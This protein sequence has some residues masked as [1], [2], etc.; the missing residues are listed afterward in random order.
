[1]KKIILIFLIVFGLFAV[2]VTQASAG[3]NLVWSG[4]DSGSIPTIE[5]S[6]TPQAAQDLYYYLPSPYDCF[7]DD[8]PTAS[9][10]NNCYGFLLSWSVG[11]GGGFAEKWVCTAG[12]WRETC[13]PRNYPCMGCS[14]KSGSWDVICDNTTTIPQATTTTSTPPTLINLSSFTAT[15]KFS[16]VIIQWSTGSEIDNAGFYIYRAT[17]EN[18]EYEKIN[19]VL[20]TAEGSATNG[21]SY[22]FTDTDVQNRRTYYYKLEDIDL[23]GKSTMHGP[24]SATPRLIYG[25]KK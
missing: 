9:F 4:D 7:I 25:M 2:N 18:G 22:T 11:L 6:R 1:M 8:L 21:A 12:N 16:K 3:C 19:N 15:P 23:N 14:G 5:T 17:A 10:G 13:H 24:V 20:I